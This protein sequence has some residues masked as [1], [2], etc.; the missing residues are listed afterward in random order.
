MSEPAAVEP[1]E[2]PDEEEVPA[3]L[4]P[5]DEPAELEEPEDTELTDEQLAQIEAAGKP[6]KDAHIAQENLKRA[7]K[8]GAPAEVLESL[9]HIAEVATEKAAEYLQKR[10]EK[11]LERLAN[12][13]ERHRNRL[14]EILEEDALNLVP[15]M[16][17]RTDLA[18][19]LDRTASIPEE[20]KAAVRIQ[21][22]DRPPRELLDDPYSEL[23]PTCHGAKEVKPTGAVGGELVL[24]CVTCGG[25]GWRPVGPERG[26]V[27]GA[28]P[29][30]P[31]VVDGAAEPSPVAP[32]LPDI[33]PEIAERYVL[34][35][36]AP[37][38]PVG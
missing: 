12:E 26:G 27:V 24:V 28:P 3:E 37:T 22:G 18:G 23:C 34:V 31:P 16:L 8:E 35:P 19:F 1:V 38:T 32:P 17:C 6:V 13:G 33:P 7:V 14:A 4:E 29:V 10:A 2:E 15:C 30:A 9:S 21:I 5:E 11:T 36:R 20:V 25:K